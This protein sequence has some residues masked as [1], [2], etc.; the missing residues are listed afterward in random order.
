MDGTFKQSEA[1]N[2]DDV[3]EIDPEKLSGMPVFRGA[4]VPI[5]NFFDYI[6]GGDTVEEFLDQFPT[7]EPEQVTELFALIKERIG[8]VG[9]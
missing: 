4:G 5:K 3:I 1:M 8:L 6:E 7:V 2:K 9:D